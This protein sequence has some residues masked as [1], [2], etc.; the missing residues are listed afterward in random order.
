VVQL[1]W[2][3]EVGPQDGE[4]EQFLPDIWKA[5]DAAEPLSHP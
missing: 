5:E 3:I 1:V 2:A 4:V